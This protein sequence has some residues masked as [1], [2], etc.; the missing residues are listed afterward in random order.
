MKKI[1]REACKILEIENDKE[2]TD[3]EKKSAIYAIIIDN[4]TYKQACDD[5]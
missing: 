5:I 4:C 2:F 3:F 1:Y